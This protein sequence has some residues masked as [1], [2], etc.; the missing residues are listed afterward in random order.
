MRPSEA[1]T[2]PCPG[3]RV[4]WARSGSGSSWV[5]RARRSTCR[6]A[7]ELA[8]SGRMTPDRT[9]SAA[10]LWSVVRVFAPSPVTSQAGESPTE[11]TIHVL[12]AA[13]THVAAAMVRVASMAARPACSCRPACTAAPARARASRTA[14]S[15]SLPCRVPKTPAAMLTASCAARAPPRCPPTPSLTI[16]QRH[17]T[18]TRSWLS[19]RCP[20]LVAQ[21]HPMTSESSHPGRRFLSL[22]PTMSALQ[23]D[24]GSRKGQLWPPRRW[25]R[26]HRLRPFWCGTGAV[27]VVGAFSDRSS[28][29]RPGRTKQRAPSQRPSRTPEVGSSK[30][31]ATASPTTCSFRC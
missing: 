28:I 20:G 31:K 26:H 27:L 22:K 5:A 4:T 2:S 14:R 25:L 12:A 9:R 7:W 24:L 16:A 1:R 17:D 11:A 19:A 29:V 3:S 8:S 23:R 10:R 13:S 6:P 30:D 18:A 21:P 15:S